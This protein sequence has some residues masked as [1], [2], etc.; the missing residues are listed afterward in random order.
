[1]SIE[2]EGEGECEKLKVNWGL[3]VWGILGGKGRERKRK[4]KEH[5]LKRRPSA[6]LLPAGTC[7]AVNGG[8][9]LIDSVCDAF[10]F[11]VLS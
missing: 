11:V 9:R 3:E 6:S 8:G 2:E 5:K 1:M 4:E 10:Y 7:R